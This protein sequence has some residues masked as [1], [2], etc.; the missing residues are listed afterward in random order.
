MPICASYL[1]PL[2][3]VDEHGMLI[4]LRVWTINSEETM[5][6]GR[7]EESPLARIFHPQMYLLWLDLICRSLIKY[8]KFHTIIEGTYLLAQIGMS[9]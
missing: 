7:E 1:V 2:S 4:Y 6:K 8:F 9:L 5:D 3:G